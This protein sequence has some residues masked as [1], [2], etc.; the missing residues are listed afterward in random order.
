VLPRQNLS[1]E[2]AG[3]TQRRKPFAFEKSKTGNVSVDDFVSHH[4]S[5]AA[6]TGGGRSASLEQILAIGQVIFQTM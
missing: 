6:Y 4:N 2:S 3:N 5:P 1:F